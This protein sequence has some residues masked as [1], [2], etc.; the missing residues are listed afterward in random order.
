MNTEGDVFWMHNTKKPLRNAAGDIVGLIGIARNVTQSKETSLAL[1][2]HEQLLSALMETFP[3]QIY[4]KDRRSRFLRVNNATF[5]WLKMASQDDLLGK[6]DFEF[7]D[8]EHAQAAFEDEQRLMQTGEPIINKEE[9]ETW[10]D[11]RTTWVSTSKLPIRDSNNRIIGLYGISRDITEQKSA[12]ENIARYTRELKEM[13]VRL[14]NDLAMAAEL[15]LAF[16]PKS[17]PSFP[18]DASPDTS[19]LQFV[20]YYLPT[21]TVGGDFFS[22]LQLSD[23]RCGIF[24]C[25]VMGHGVRAALV[26]AMIRTIISEIADSVED[27]GSFL[28][29]VNARMVRMV[30]ME[31]KTM[32]A[33]ACFIVIDTDT[34]ELTMANAGHPNPLL[35]KRSQGTVVPLLP[36]DGNTDPALGLSDLSIY[37]TITVPLQPRDNI[38]LYTDGLYEVE[39]DEGVYFDHDRLQAAI[40]RQIDRPVETL[41]AG[42]LREIRKFSSNPRFEDDVCMLSVD[43]RAG[44]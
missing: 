23:T 43:Y 38:V 26:T 22:V 42:L 33:S 2:Q 19:L 28:S 30:Q 6:T 41:F 12:Q 40:L 34:G 5:R 44:G 8:Y 4:F 27:P 25:D 20:H 11:G 13:N 16:L 15:Q 14:E 35:L 3:D 37:E 1:K 10:P 32:F 36:E 31:W 24:F 21:G 39:G 9:K 18:P 7:F 29:E 17:Y